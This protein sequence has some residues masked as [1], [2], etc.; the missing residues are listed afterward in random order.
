MCESKANQLNSDYVMKAVETLSMMKAFAAF[1]ECRSSPG[2]L[3][4]L[5][6]RCC[7]FPLRPV[8]HQRRGDAFLVRLPAVSGLDM[9]GFLRTYSWHS[10][11]TSENKTF[12][13][14]EACCL[15]QLRFMQV[16]LLP[17]PLPAKR[18]WP[19]KETTLAPYESST[20]PPALD[21]LSCS[22]SEVQSSRCGPQLVWRTVWPRW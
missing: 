19:R 1:I 5:D 7:G 12:M 4:K 22:G 14:I 13:T 15:T 8:R 16:C 6:E 3:H 17:A 11:G 20:R 21:L 10:V 2:L 18:C 9:F